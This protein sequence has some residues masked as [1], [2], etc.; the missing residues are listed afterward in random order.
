MKT[1]RESLLN[2]AKLASRATEKKNNIPAL[3]CLLIESNQITGCD[4]K[5]Q[6]I[7]KMMEPIEGWESVAAPAD[8]LV[9]ILTA[10]PKGADVSL[11]QDD[12]HI[13]IKS[14]RSRFKLS[15]I[16]AEQFPDY[17]RS[18]AEGLRNSAA[19]VEAMCAMKFAAP[20]D[21]TRHYLN[22][23]LVEY[24]DGVAQYVV[25]TDG[26]RL[27]AR[28]MEPS[29]EFQRAIIPTSAVV[30][31]CS[32]FG[33][34]DDVVIR[35]G[36]NV[37]AE[38]G[39][40]IYRSNLIEG[41]YPDWRRIV[42]SFEAPYTV[43]RDSLVSAIRQAEITANAKVRAAR[44]FFESGSARVESHN[45]DHDELVAEFDCETSLDP[46]EIGVNL[47]YLRDCAEAIDSDHIT[48]HVAE[49]GKPL[50]VRHED[51]VHLVMPIRL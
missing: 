5:R 45:P 32:L 23:L 25:G 12:G 6:V 7:A 30:D 15:T 51:D 48:V 47:A 33:S 10:L 20:T 16:P 19:L 9:N 34:V 3:S 21:D 14:G 2:A 46:V 31:I 18:G 36:R 41:N 50:L 11:K 44:F 24:Q 49:P 43:P 37:E 1:T 27:S 28:K 39:D 35:L 17:A 42:P 22:G 40:V 8:K 29:K 38:A 4:L 13:I 26:H